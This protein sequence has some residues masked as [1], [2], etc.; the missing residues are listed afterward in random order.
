VY[1]ST[2]VPKGELGFYIVSEG[3]KSPYRCR[4]RSSA[5]NNLSSLALQIQGELVA[6]VVACIGSLDPVMGE[7]DR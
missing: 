6:D 2:E 7:V 4:I 5:F 3:G 1:L